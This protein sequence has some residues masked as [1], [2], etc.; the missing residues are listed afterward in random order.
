MVECFVVYIYENEG[1]IDPHFY[2]PEFRELEKKLNILNYKKLG[3]I[4]Q[5]SNETWNQKDF[6]ENEFPY[7]EISEIDTTSGKIRDIIYYEKDK[8][9][10]RAKMIVREN[11]IIVST[12]RP[13][14]GAISLID[15]DKD[16]FIASTGFAILRESKI[17][18]KRKYLFFFLRTQLALKQMLQRSSGGNYPAITSRELRKIIIPIPSFSVQ[19][20]IIQIMDNAYSS[21]KQKEQEA[22]Q[23]L[24]SID[25]YVLTELGMDFPEVEEKK[26]FA[27]LS[28][29]INK[30]RINPYYYLPKFSKLNESLKKGNYEIVK[31]NEIVSIS[32][33]IINPQEKPEDIFIY[34]D[35]ASINSKT[36]QIEK[37]KKITGKD[38]PSRARMLIRE[39]DL[40]ISSLSGSIDSIAIVPE[41]LDNQV[42][43]TGFFVINKS[44]K[45]NNIYL[46]AVLRTKLFQELLIKEASGAIMSAIP[47]VKFESFKIPIPPL[48]EQQKIANEVKVMVETAERLKKEAKKEL[49]EAKKK[50]EEIILG[51]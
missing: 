40:L 6:Y 39:G 16:K 49:E 47:K 48:P 11:D 51:G 29:V 25:D 8:A 38:A 17:K 26:T 28:D 4:I 43:S 20:K 1:R 31:L 35:L 32:D 12:T 3:E 24:N 2:K 37:P 18:I 27:V 42:A 7:I 13:H 19:N 15:K 14:R 30:S 41:E 5:F 33:K 21:K 9:P 34:V 46:F 36:G 45:L 50:V 22:K 10:S 23:L 44:R